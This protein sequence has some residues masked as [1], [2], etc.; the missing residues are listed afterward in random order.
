MFETSLELQCGAKDPAM[1]C[2]NAWSRNARKSSDGKI[3]IYC[4]T[5]FHH[6]CRSSTIRLVGDALGEAFSEE[7][8]CLDLEYREAAK[9]VAGMKAVRDKVRVPLQFFFNHLVIREL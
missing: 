3:N 9:R 4:F 7:W 1:M 8:G 5:A 2:C 6:S